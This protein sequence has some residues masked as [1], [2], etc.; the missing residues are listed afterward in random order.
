MSPNRATFD[1]RLRRSVRGE[2]ARFRPLSDASRIEQAVATGNRT[3][4]PAVLPAL[5]AVALAVV[6]AIRTAASSAPESAAVRT[7]QPIRSASASLGPGSAPI[8]LA[9]CQIAPADSFLAFA[10]W[11]TLDVL[12]VGGGKAAPEQRIYAVV[13]RGLAEWVGWKSSGGAMY[14]RPVGR[15]GCIYDPSSGESSLVGVPLDWQPPAVA[16]RLAPRIDP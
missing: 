9:D 7:P 11:T 4:V 12:H 13:T 15:M 8:G 1:E 14:P 16:I 6:L 5:P 2:A 10:G 3:R